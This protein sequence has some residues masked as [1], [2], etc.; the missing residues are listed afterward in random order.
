M[1]GPKLSGVNWA[2][3]TSHLLFTLFTGEILVY[4]SEGEYIVR[5]LPLFSEVSELVY[6]LSWLLIL[7]KCWTEYKYR[8]N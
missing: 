8:E 4:D 1:K 7:L 3:D 2:P 6:E 5:L